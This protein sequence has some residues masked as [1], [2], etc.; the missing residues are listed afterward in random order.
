MPNAVPRGLIFVAILAAIV[1]TIVLVA[2]IDR[3]PPI[4]SSIRATRDRPHRSLDDP[5]SGPG[6]YHGRVFGPDN[7]VSDDGSVAVAAR[8]TWVTRTVKK[9]KNSTTT[10]ICTLHVDDGLRLVDGDVRVPLSLSGTVSV[11]D[12][13]DSLK[14]TQ[15]NPIFDFGAEIRSSELPTSTSRWC[16]VPTG[17]TVIHHE[18]RVRPGAELWV[19][20]CRVDGVLR[21][22]D[23]PGD[24][25]SSRGPTAVQERLGAD[26]LFVLRLTWF[27]AVLPL[28][29][30]AF[31]LGK[32]H[33]GGEESA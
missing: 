2:A 16:N 9:G 8:I 30:I 6:I 26:T 19:S 11:V 5:A 15:N 14:A 4:A 27:I 31:I 1:S 18:V 25:I 33:V 3:V 32:Q 21:R 22:C 13:D 23:R 24:W 10:R 17:G 12:L 29:I 28:L 7:R 20:L